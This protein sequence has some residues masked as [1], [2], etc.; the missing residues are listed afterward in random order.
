MA[1][2]IISGNWL[3]PLL[4]GALASTPASADVSPV[5]SMGTPVMVVPQYQE[6]EHRPSHRRMEA[7]C[8]PVRPARR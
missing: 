3:V 2:T 7:R 8:L 1:R 4:C 5:T 6:L